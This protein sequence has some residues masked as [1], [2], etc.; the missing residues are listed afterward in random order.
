MKYI[1]YLEYINS[2]E[3][4]SK[5]KQFYKSKLYKNYKGTSK[6]NC[7]CCMV[8]DVPLDLHHRTYKRLG[9]E[10][11]A[12]DLVPVCRKCHIDIHKLANQG[13]DLWSA[14]KRIKNRNKRKKYRSGKASKVEG[15]NILS[16]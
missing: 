11:I 5:R 3:W 8:G 2:I 12:V 9:N 16:E 4:Q 1:N 13:I 6:W 10:N 7:Y 14:T 15:K